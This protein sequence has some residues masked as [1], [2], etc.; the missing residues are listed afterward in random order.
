MALP[1]GSSASTATFTIPHSYSLRTSYVSAMS[2]NID[3]FSTGVNVSERQI[4][5]YNYSNSQIKYYR[6]K[7]T[8]YYVHCITCGY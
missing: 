8:T 1:P 2:P 4:S 3:E 6:Y 5:L 7:S